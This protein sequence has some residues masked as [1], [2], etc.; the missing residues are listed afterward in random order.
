MFGSAIIE[1]VIGLAFVYFI[2]S[3]VAS[4]INEMIAGFFGFRGNDLETAIRTLLADDPGLADDVWNHGMVSGLSGKPGRAPSYVPSSNFALALLAGLHKDSEAQLDAQSI[5]TQVI[6]LPEGNVR[7]AMLAIVNDSGGDLTRIRAGIEDWYNAAM[8]RV[9]GT[10][11]RKIQ[12]VMLGIAAVLTLI[13]GVDSIAIETTMWQDQALRS[14]LTGAAQS[15]SAAGGTGGLEDTLNTL[16]QFD[17][18][19]G[20]AV[21]PQTAFGWFLK[22]I[23]L[24]LSALAVSLGAPFWF[25]FL[26][27]VLKFNPRSSGP[28]PAK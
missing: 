7:Q 4:H 27:K 15:A 13:F 21:L 19:L 8:D 25:D 17:L 9:T 5:R 22:V 16:S 20:W 12:W 24:V 26:N 10:Y 3:V 18:P 14:A 23:G 6:D 2:L 1:V 11:K 28:A